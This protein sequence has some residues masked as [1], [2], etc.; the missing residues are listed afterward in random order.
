[1]QKIDPT[2][3]ELRMLPWHCDV[4]LGLTCMSVNTNQSQQEAHV[5]HV[6]T[7]TC[8]PTILVFCPMM[9]FC[10]SRRIKIWSS[11]PAAS[12]T[13]EWRFSKHP[14]FLDQPCPR[15]L[16]LLH[17]PPPPTPTPRLCA[18]LINTIQQGLAATCMGSSARHAVRLKVL[19]WPNGPCVLAWPVV[20]DHLYHLA[21]RL[22]LWSTEKKQSDRHIKAIMFPLCYILIWS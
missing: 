11:Q 21:C 14:S 5:R 6:Q 3:K 13:P 15:R 2:K 20:S 19:A 10:H 18:S 9:P 17:A 12:K 1:M 22:W 16:S 4:P 8:P 7:N